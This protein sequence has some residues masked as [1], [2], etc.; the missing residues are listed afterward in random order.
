MNE[1]TPLLLRAAR[2]ENVERPPV[3]MMRQAGRYMKE[4]HIIKNKFE[5]YSGPLH[6]VSFIP[7]GLTTK[8]TD[9]WTQTKVNELK[10]NNYMLSRPKF[11]GKYYLRVVMGNYNT[12]DSHIEELLRF[13]DAYQ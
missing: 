3:W 4:Y 5:I 8:D 13:L 2:G 11:K 12:K 6:I 1:T 7:K 10:K 9:S